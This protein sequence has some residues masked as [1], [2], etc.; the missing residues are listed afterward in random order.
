MSMLVSQALRRLAALKGELKELEARGTA[1]VSYQKDS[2]PAYAWGEVF[3]SQGKVRMELAHLKAKLAKTNALTQFEFEGKSISLTEAV[4]QLGELKATIKWLKDLSVKP[5]A[6]TVEKSHDYDPDTMKRVVNN[7]EWK[8]DFPE[9][10]RGD[11]VAKF[12]KQFASLNDAVEAV[13]NKTTLL[14]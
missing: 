14:V 8:C 3:E 7:I 1:A 4:I 12:Q 11:R 9:K 2:P 6:T 13:N 10:E 5:Q